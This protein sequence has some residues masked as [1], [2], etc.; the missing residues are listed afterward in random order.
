MSGDALAS[1]VVVA[2]HRPEKLA[3][4]LPMLRDDRLEVVVVNVE[5]DAEVARIAGTSVVPLSGNPGYGAAVN[6]GAR[7][8]GAPVI[9]FMND[10]VCLDAEDVLDL[11]AVVSS[12]RAGVVLPGIIDSN[13]RREPTVAALPS[14]RNL[15][16]EW[17]L[18]PDRPPAALGRRHL[19]VQKWR[20]PMGPE[21]VDAASA[22]VVA[23][24]AALLRT[25][26]LPEDYFL[27]WEESD[28]FWRLKAAGERV[29]YD[30]TKV[31][32]HAG[33]RDDVRP[34][35]SRLLARNAVRCV[36]RTQ[37][38][39]AALLAWPVVVLWNLRLAAVDGL[40][41]MAGSPD[42]GRRLPARAAGLRA[43]AMAWHEL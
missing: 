36:R 2:F 26:P 35:K 12:R 20:L 14:P 6:A 21:V 23:T 29:L 27:Y 24:S 18:L 28:W 38:R 16:V 33:G 39:G 17:F 43:A 25:H 31:A 37:G 40:R 8:A 5:N 7:R 10:D 42:A 19:G 9:V 30:P 41:R 11:A 32:I 22:A 1:C 4:L 34:D 15:F 13:G 3:A